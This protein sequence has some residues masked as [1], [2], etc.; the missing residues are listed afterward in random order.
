MSLL[1]LAATGY[2]TNCLGV[3]RKYSQVYTVRYVC[4]EH[5]KDLRVRTDLMSQTLGLSLVLPTYG[6]VWPLAVSLVDRDRCSWLLCG[7]QRQRGP[8]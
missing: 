7:A 3:G 1:K 8:I 6:I 5:E 4:R 2:D